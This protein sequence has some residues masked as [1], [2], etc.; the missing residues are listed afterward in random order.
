MLLAMRKKMFTNHVKELMV[1]RAWGHS[2]WKNRE[3]DGDWRWWY[4][5]LGTLPETNM[6]PE[7]GWL[8][9]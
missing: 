5:L 2:V 6:A 8:E 1:S 7:N 3:V 9:N 4:F